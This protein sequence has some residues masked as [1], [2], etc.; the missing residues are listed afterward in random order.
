MYQ[1]EAL[2]RPWLRWHILRVLLHK[3]VLRQLANRGGIVLALLLIGLSLLLSLGK[4]STRGP[5]LGGNVQLCYLIYKRDDPAFQEIRPW[6][7]A[8]RDH[9]PP[10]WTESDFR[11]RRADQMT[12]DKDGK[13]QF[14]ANAGSIQIESNGRDERGQWKYKVDI[15]YPGD[16]D[17]VLSSYETWFWRETQRYFLPTR[18]IQHGADERHRQFG[19]A[20]LYS[21]LAPVPIFFALFFSCVYL[22][23]SLT[24]EERERGILLAQALSPASPLEILVSK[25][26]FYAVIGIGLSAILAGIYRPGVLIER[27][28]WLALISW[29][30][31]ALSIGLTIATLAGTQRLA[32]VG[33]MCYLLM[34]AL[35]ITIS[36]QMNISALPWLFVEYHGENMMHAAL[37]G[38]ID[39]SHWFHL[40]VAT[41]L[42]ICWAA[43]ATVLFRYRGWQ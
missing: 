11:I 32:S 5:L 25:F 28:F 8:L 24:C 36:Q 15:W 14:P 12:V 37:A 20:D 33:A 27:F 41:I 6:V 13:I 1:A 35:F 22:L 31:G 38:S 26:L 9:K 18:E 7:I 42:A 19:S 4:S 23:P 3:E 21:A 16:N 17:A 30:L 34:V 29:S 40:V 43:L 2:R 10:E 39:M